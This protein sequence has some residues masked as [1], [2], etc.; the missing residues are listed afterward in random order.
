ME[1]IEVSPLPPECIQ[2]DE[3]ECYNCDNAGKRWVLS[4]EDEQ[5]LRNCSVK[6]QKND[7]K[8]TKNKM[9]GGCC[10]CRTYC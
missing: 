7:I 4:E 2:C 8:E 3:D 5:S 9:C 6:R 10:F 1:Y